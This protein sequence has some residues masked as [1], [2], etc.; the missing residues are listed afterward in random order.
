LWG[1]L[2][3]VRVQSIVSKEYRLELAGV[4]CSEGGAINVVTGGSSSQQAVAPVATGAAAVGVRPCYA[5]CP[6]GVGGRRQYVLHRHSVSK[7]IAAELF[8]ER[9]R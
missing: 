7:V 9:V 5:W 1:R 6:V 2:G 3:R 4:W 8:I